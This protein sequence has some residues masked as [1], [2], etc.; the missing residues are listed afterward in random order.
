MLCNVTKIIGQEMKIIQQ[1]DKV[2]VGR[3]LF[4][5]ARFYYSCILT[6]NYSGNF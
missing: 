4:R 6:V 2:G 3:N 5:N 1:N